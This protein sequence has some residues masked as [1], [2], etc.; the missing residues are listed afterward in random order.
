MGL[1]GTPELVRSLSRFGTDLEKGSK[2]WIALLLLLD[3]G[4]GDR[5][6]CY[7]FH[8]GILPVESGV[9]QKIRDRAEMRML[10]SLPVMQL[11]QQIRVDFEKTAII[12]ECVIEK[13][14][15]SR[16][17]NDWYIGLSQSIHEKAFHGFEIGNVFHL[18]LYEF[19]YLP[20]L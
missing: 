8:V 19:P 7:V 3:L 10:F 2:A 11:L 6:M 12:V 4:F 18:S 15:K 20:D 9:E 14:L 13:D 1:L 17:I 5:I 16:P